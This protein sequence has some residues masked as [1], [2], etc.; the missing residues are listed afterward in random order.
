L[1]IILPQGQVDRIVKRLE[2][3]YLAAVFVVGPQRAVR[4]QHQ[5]DEPLRPADFFAFVI[6]IALPDSARF[7]NIVFIVVALVGYYGGCNVIPVF[8]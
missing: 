6:L 2:N 7:F 4:R 1:K 3:E 8:K 5:A